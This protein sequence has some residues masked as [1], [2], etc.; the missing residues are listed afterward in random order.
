MYNTFKI[1]CMGYLGEAGHYIEP[2][3]WFLNSTDF[4]ESPTD[5]AEATAI[6]L[7]M[8]EV[9]ET[10]HQSARFFL[11]NILFSSFSLVESTQVPTY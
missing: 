6:M 8:S 7:Q 3:R 9:M 1:R 11:Q 2:S 5:D 10:M 4:A